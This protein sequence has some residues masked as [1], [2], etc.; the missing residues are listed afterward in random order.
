MIF[1]YFCIKKLAI[2]CGVLFILKTFEKIGYIKLFYILT[3]CFVAIFVS[4]A[5]VKD[6]TGN[7]SGPV[8]KGSARPETG[9]RRPGPDRK[10]VK[11]KTAQP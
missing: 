2:M 11:G 5:L 10:P 9:K 8:K 7:R 3:L 4:S 6:R 1:L